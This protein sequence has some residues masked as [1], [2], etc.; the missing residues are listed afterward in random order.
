M[1]RLSEGAC[2]PRVRGWTSDAPAIGKNMGRPVDCRV[3]V[4]LCRVQGVYVAKSLLLPCVC[5]CV[6]VAFCMCACVYVS[7]CVGV[8]GGAGACY[9]LS[10]SLFVLVMAASRTRPVLALRS[11]LCSSLSSCT[12]IYIYVYICIKALPS[13]R[14][15]CRGYESAP[16]PDGRA[17][18]Q[19][20]KHPY[21][22]FA[23]LGSA[24]TPGPRERGTP[25]SI[26]REGPPPSKGGSG[27]VHILKF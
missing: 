25:P 17:A 14:G 10:L 12:H 15:R 23:S 4:W 27:D 18:R 22:S 5:V 16:S 24:D 9:L 21:A 7:L 3:S 20:D 1:P 8:P 19:L 26:V 11:W 6:R 13:R 2:F